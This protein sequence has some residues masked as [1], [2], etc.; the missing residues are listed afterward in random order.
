MIDYRWQGEWIQDSPIDQHFKRLASSPEHHGRWITYW[1]E[2]SFRLGLGVN[3]K[4][5]TYLDAANL[6][7]IK[8]KPELN[9]VAERRINRYARLNIQF[10]NLTNNQQTELTLLPSK[11]RVDVP[12]QDRWGHPLPGRRI[13]IG[14][15]IKDRP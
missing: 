11:H 5:H 4:S 6:R 15:T 1:I 7:L 10:F 2:K 12:H 14:L 9:L 8:S 3:I 13:Q